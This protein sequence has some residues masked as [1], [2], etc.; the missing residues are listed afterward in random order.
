MYHWLSLALREYSA[1]DIVV[2]ASTIDEA[3]IKVLNGF[4]DY[5]WKY[6]DWRQKDDQ[7][8]IAAFTDAWV[9]LRTDLQK[10]PEIKEIVWIRGGE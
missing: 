7:D 1:G 3:R 4:A 10:D 9:A 5:W 2:I 8:D 6:H